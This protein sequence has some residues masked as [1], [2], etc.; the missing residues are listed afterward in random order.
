MHRFLE[1]PWWLMLVRFYKMSYRRPLGFNIFA[2]KLHWG[3]SGTPTGWSDGEVISGNMHRSTDDHHS[4]SWHFIPIW[5]TYITSSTN[6]W[7]V[8]QGKTTGLILNTDFWNLYQCRHPLDL[9]YGRK[10]TFLVFN[11]TRWSRVWI[12]MKHE[13]LIFSQM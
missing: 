6:P 2:D 4:F 1:L 8:G 9:T 10:T 11:V 7:M 5:E 12:K 3:K 13:E